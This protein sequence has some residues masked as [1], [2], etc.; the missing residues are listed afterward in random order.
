MQLFCVFIS[1]FVS[2]LQIE[3]KN[4][5]GMIYFPVRQMLSLDNSPMALIMTLVTDLSNSGKFGR[6]V[7][8]FLT[9]KMLRKLKMH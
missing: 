1:V 9:L 8:H 5:T 4:T 3:T 6:S 2:L 7:P